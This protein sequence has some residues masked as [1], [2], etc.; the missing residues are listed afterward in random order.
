M[1]SKTRDASK[2]P[3][4]YGA[5]ERAKEMHSVDILEEV[6]GLAEYYGF[7]VRREFLGE[8]TRGACRIGGHWILF[9]DLSLPA[10]EQLSQVIAAVR[11]TGIVIP[12]ASTSRTLHGLLS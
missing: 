12:L 4:A 7:E 11:S 3:P 2:S 10:A 6:I 8:S 9:V 5:S 1:L